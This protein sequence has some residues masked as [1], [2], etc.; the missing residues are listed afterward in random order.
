MDKK[1]SKK[2]LVL[3]APECQLTDAE[4]LKEFAKEKKI[5]YTI[6]N[7]I[8]GPRLGSGIPRM[9]LFDVKGKLVFA[10]HPMSEDADK[11]IRT[12][13]K[14]AKPDGDDEEEDS[15]FSKKEEKRDLVAER[16]W[17]NSEGKTIK[18]T[19]ISLD[20]KTGHFKFPNGKT[21][22]YEITKLSDADQIVIKEAAEAAEKAAEEEEE[23]E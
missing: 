7:N 6:T 1:Y 10:G 20:D 14:D 13:L 12:A 21:F 5:K 2:G 19:L 22:D 9:A 4:K 23:D 15:F 18:A 11:A 3:V 17:T 16:S 8:R